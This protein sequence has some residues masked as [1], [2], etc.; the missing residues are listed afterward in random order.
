MTN[1]SISTPGVIEYLAE[2][3]PYHQETQ[4]P[5]N[6]L[7]TSL[8]PVIFSETIA[9]A[10]TSETGTAPAVNMAAESSEVPEGQD[11]PRLAEELK[12]VA[13]AEA[14]PQGDKTKSP[15]ILI[16]EDTTELAEI[17]QATLERI[18]MVTMHETHGG[19][20]LAVLNE[21]QPDVVLLDISLP[22]MTGWKILDAIKERHEANKKP[23]PL[24]I[25]ITAYD[26]PAN[27]LVGK[28][29]GIYS[30]L[31]KPFTADEV[32]KAVTQALSGAP[33]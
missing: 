26:D 19:R 28:L 33:R 21:R 29:Q 16:I 18:Q 32:E 15:L 8:M 22:D 3:S 12:T 25:V 9:E 31:I 6:P 13:V 23:M 30:Y 17:I 20:A 11:A 7:K 14:A 5:Y 2:G 1:L 10:A 24:V 4:E 27:R